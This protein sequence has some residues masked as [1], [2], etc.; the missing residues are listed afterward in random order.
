M[1]HRQLESKLAVAR[2]DL[3][4]GEARYATQLAKTA[5][6]PE[7]EDDQFGLAHGA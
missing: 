4:A 2:Q 6:L 7:E 5:P 3:E 1:R